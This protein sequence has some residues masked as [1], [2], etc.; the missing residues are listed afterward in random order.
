MANMEE[1]SE[2][3]RVMLERINGNAWSIE[4]RQADEE[5]SEL[6]YLGSTRKGNIIRDY[7]V[8]SQGQYWYRNR[9]VVDGLIVSMEVYIFG[10]DARA[11]QRGVKKVQKKS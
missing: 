6:L 8:D 1:Y 11:L 3:P 7:Y 10:K 4:S 9:A 2:I 5:S